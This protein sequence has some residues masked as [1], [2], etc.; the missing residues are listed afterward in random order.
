MSSL[1]GCFNYNEP[2]NIPKNFIKPLNVVSTPGRRADLFLKKKTANNVHH[3]YV[4]VRYE[5]KLDYSF[6]ADEDF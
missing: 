5:M 4:E 6:E 1:F 2:L 3:V